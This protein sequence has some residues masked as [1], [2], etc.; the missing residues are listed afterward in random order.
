MDRGA[1]ASGELGV[2]ARNKCELGIFACVMP[3]VLVGKRR[4]RR[5]HAKDDEHDERAPGRRGLHPV[6]S[7]REAKRKA[8]EA[9]FPSTPA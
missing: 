9:A 3:L 4:L 5:E 1:W 2:D 7:S 8:A 6:H